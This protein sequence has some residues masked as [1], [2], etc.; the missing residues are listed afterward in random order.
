MKETI[1]QRFMKVMYDEIVAPFG[2]QIQMQKTWKDHG[3]DDIEELEIVL[4]IEDE[5]IVDISDEDWM[6]HCKTPADL[7][8]FLHKK[9]RDE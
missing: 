3:L 4:A 1:E 6:Q 8:A 9:V 7:L 2:T 5:F